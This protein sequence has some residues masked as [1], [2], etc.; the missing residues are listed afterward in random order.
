MS[1]SP[2]PPSRPEVGSGS[3]SVP[4]PGTTPAGS[5]APRSGVTAE[6][7]GSEEHLLDLIARATSHDG[8]PPFSDGSLVE[9]RSGERR[10]VWLDDVAVALVTDKEAEFVVDPAA[11]RH[12]H[13][14]ELLHRLLVDA[15]ADLLIWAHGAHPAALALAAH[16]G[17]QPVRQLLQLRL[18]LAEVASCVDVEA[19]TS[20]QVATSRKITHG[21]TGH[22]DAWLELN[23]R[24]F[25]AH[26]EQG[27]VTRA[28]LDALM[29]EDWFE[30]DD[31]LLLWDG[32][33]LIGYCW[34]KIERG[35]GDAGQVSTGSTSE[36]AGSTSSTNGT[37][38]TSESDT[39][40][41]FYVVGVDP[42]RQGEGI[43]RVLVAAGLDHL[44]SRGIPIAH[45]YVEGDNIA[46]VRLYRSFGFRDYALDIQYRWR[47]EPD[48]PLDGG[49]L[50]PVARRGNDVHREA[51]PW[52]PTIHR[53]LNHLRSNGV[54]W[55]PEPRGFDQQ[56]REILEFVEGVVPAYPMPEWVWD[57]SVLVDAG[58]RLREL[59]DA[60]VSFPRAD[61]T[62]RMPP[63]GDE[64]ICHN[65]FAPYNLVFRDGALAGAI[66][67]DTV[68]PG[69][70]LWDIAYLAYRAVPLNDR[71]L[72]LSIPNRRARLQMLLDAYGSDATI[73]EL[74]QMAV[75]RL[76]DLAEFTE[77]R[78]KKTG[79]TDL[80]EHV[81]LY[82]HDAASLPTLL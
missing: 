82:R 22:E 29:R 54:D 27:R 31:V 21:M 17:L 72:E 79:R 71:D 39:V 35:S 4:E 78:A 8:N 6:R 5:G 48:E 20:T 45:L 50:T 18:N 42:T 73:D 13:G 67:F 64:V 14:R 34:M 37:S 49:N 62:W 57:E 33:A 70:R 52:T 69:T 53:L 81:D 43:G 19:Q 11:R 65:D 38:S 36:E 44:A 25:A 74:A 24:A 15:P 68:S 12:G 40:G 76:T 51:G 7:V 47:S 3:A 63:H 41:E 32:D 2:P 16:F 75:A 28:D 1:A 56:G 10:A 30:D 9:L 59:H 80:L 58:R 77:Q 61:A 55:V 46:A 66:D 60:S 23:A 26:P